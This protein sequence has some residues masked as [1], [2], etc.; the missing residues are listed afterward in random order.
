MLREL[1]QYYRV[2]IG[3]VASSMILQRF[4]EILKESDPETAAALEEE[5]RNDKD[6]ADL[7][8]LGR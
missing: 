6:L 1:G 3:K 4:L 2:P 8:D 5:H 7:L